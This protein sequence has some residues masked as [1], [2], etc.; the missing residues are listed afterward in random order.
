MDQNWLSSDTKCRLPV[1]RVHARQPLTWV[2]LLA[3]Q[4]F[5]ISPPGSGL[6]LALALGPPP[7]KDA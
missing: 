6:D 5:L 1:D 4:R 2:Q 3:I 7:G